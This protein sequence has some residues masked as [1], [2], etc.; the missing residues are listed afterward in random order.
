MHGIGYLMESDEEIFRLEIKTDPEIVKREAL[1]AGLKPGMKIADIGCGSG[2]TTAI[3]YDLVQPGGKATGVDVSKERIAHAVA[4]YG[5]DGLDFTC[6]DMLRPLDG[7]VNFDFVW[8][9][10]LLEYY[11]K[12]S[13]DIVRNIDRILKPGG[14][15]CLIDLDYNSLSHY[16]LSPK[17]ES[18]INDAMK[19][20]EEKANFDPYVGRKLY[21]F[22]FDLGYQDIDV[23]IGAHHLIF[24]ELKET[25]AF[26]WMKKIELVSPKI[27]NQFRGTDWEYD[28]FIRDFQD[29]FY[30]PRR[31]TYSPLICCRGRKPQ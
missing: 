26:N 25:D 22:L 20:L 11:R 16:G 15:L 13:F 21:S 1:W 8:V 6:Q 9:R 3:L 10:F 31:F 7:L 30:N 23:K 17:L 14:T 12:E 28:E 19:A 4:Q 29:F 2:K 18:T 24:G 27:C 5:H